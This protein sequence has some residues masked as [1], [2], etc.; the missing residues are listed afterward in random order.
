M[1]GRDWSRM[2]RCMDFWDNLERKTSHHVFCPPATSGILGRFNKMKSLSRTAVNMGENLQSKRLCEDHI[3]EGE[4]QRH[5]HESRHLKF[6]AE[7]TE[8]VPAFIACQ[9]PESSSSTPSLCLP[10]WEDP[11]NNVPGPTTPGHSLL[12]VSGK[13]STLIML[14]VFSFHSSFIIS[15]EQVPDKGYQVLRFASS[16]SSV[17][18]LNLLKAHSETQEAG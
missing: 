2:G 4:G 5:W 15:A 1:E 17:V 12:E 7:V 18:K 9:Q 10:A 8:N 3:P 13:C 16:V 6:G 11:R 14:H